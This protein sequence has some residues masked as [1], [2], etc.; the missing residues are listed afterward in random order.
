MN[1][2]LNVLQSILLPFALIPILQFCAMP[3]VSRKLVRKAVV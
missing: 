2:T 1:D 3:S